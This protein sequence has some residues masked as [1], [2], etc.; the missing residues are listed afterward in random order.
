MPSG[1]PYLRLWPS[2]RHDHSM[3]CAADQ[4]GGHPAKFHLSVD[5][6]QVTN[7]RNIPAI[8]EEDAPL[9]RT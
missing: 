1:G 8:P 7:K 6:A 9:P 2:C 5:Y 4:I 3:G